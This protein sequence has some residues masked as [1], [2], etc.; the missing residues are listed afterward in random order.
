MAKYMCSN[1][2]SNTVTAP[3]RGRNDVPVDD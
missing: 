1:D 2:E 3:T